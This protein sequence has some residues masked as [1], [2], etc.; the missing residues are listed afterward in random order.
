MAK[1]CEVGQCPPGAPA[2]LVV[3]C[4]GNKMAPANRSGMQCRFRGGLAS[5]ATYDDENQTF[6]CMAP[7]GLSAEE[8]ADF[9]VFDGDGDFL[10][11]FGDSPALQRCEDPSSYVPHRTRVRMSPYS[12]WKAVERNVASTR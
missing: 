12:C 1:I 7:L 8:L 11:D 6:S 5:S 9:K 4:T 10:C 3:T 2:E